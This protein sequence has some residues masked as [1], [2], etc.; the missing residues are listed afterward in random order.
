LKKHVQKGPPGDSKAWK[1]GAISAEFYIG[2]IV[3]RKA[4]MGRFVS[5]SEYKGKKKGNKARRQEEFRLFTSV[6][7]I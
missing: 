4:M 2:H 1:S 7:I 5:N 3:Y 6:Y